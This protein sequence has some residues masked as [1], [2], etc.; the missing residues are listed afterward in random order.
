MPT[1]LY[2]RL[3]RTIQSVGG[4]AYRWVDVPP[5]SGADGGQPGG[6]IRNAFLYN[7]DRV[8]ITPD[9]VQRIGAADPA[10]EDSRKPLMVQFRML[11]T[12]CELAVINVHLASKRHQR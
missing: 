12:N 8:A 7:P 3:V 2:Q 1:S 10:F 4:P 5:Q 6:N 9:S 11:S